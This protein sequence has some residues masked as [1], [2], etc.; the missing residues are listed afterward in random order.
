MKV[1][2]Y[3]QLYKKM[4]LEISLDE[5]KLLSAMIESILYSEIVLQNDNIILCY[6]IIDEF[7]KL[8]NVIEK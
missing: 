3:D 8:L 4:E 6:D 2:S 1:N 5:I 7:D